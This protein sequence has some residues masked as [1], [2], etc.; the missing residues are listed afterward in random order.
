MILEIRGERPADAPS[1][2]NVVSDA[3][4]TMD[5]ANL[6]RGLRDHYP[7]FDARLSLTA[8]ADD[9]MVGHALFTPA[10]VRIMGATLPAVSLGPIA[11]KKA[12]QKKGIGSQLIR[13][14]HELAG[15]LGFRFAFLL[16]HPTYYSRFGY[17]ESF[18]FGKIKL[19]ISKL[20]KPG[21]KF[22]I[23]PVLPADIP[24]LVER[25]ETEWQDVD[26]NWRFGT[27]L[28][29]WRLPFLN[30][31]MWWTEDGRRAAYTVDLPGPAKCRMLLADLPDL[32]RE[33]IFTIR[34]PSLEQHP[35][36]WLAK[37]AIS[38]NWGTAE[39]KSSPAAMACPLQE[40]VLDP[41]WKERASDS[42]PPGACF[43]PLP[44]LAC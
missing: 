3:F 1:I 27:A 37:N 33:V 34:P 13:H 25:F 2:D 29:E 5:E 15:R 10:M 21:R 7:A 32:A 18:G 39:A 16:G 42:R 9:E 17:K 28:S 24:W 40:D 30:A 23:Q 8:W 19:D 36:G 35:S 43:F 22:R 11:V 26:F 41:L 38:S 4:G 12:L 20:P 14:G 31:R 6:V 44:F